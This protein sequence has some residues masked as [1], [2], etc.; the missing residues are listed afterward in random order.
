MK[1]KANNFTTS[2]MILIKLSL[3]IFK[4]D[5]IRSFSTGSH[6]KKFEEKLFRSLLSYFV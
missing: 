2:E 1:T 6:N 5:I 4:I 3:L